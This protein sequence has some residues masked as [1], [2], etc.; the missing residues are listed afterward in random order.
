MVHQRYI[1]FSFEPSG[2]HLLDVVSDKSDRTFVYYS[3]FIKAVESL[4]LSEKLTAIAVC[5]LS[6]RFAHQQSQK[7]A[8]ERRHEDHIFP[9]INVWWLLQDYVNGKLELKAK[10]MATFFGIVEVPNDILPSLWFFVSVDGPGTSWK[11]GFTPSWMEGQDQFSPWF[12]REFLFNLIR[13]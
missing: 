9:S 5:D 3:D 2:N 4:L 8:D 1:S 10:I 6:L 7:N 13:R 12:E 11:I